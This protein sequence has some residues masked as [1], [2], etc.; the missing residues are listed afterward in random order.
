MLILFALDCGSQ[1]AS[2]EGLRPQKSVL[3]FSWFFAVFSLVITKKMELLLW[4]AFLARAF[5]H[6]MDKM[7][8]FLCFCVS[9]NC[10]RAHPFPLPLLPD[11]VATS[12]FYTT[13]SHIEKKLKERRKEGERETEREREERKRKRESVGARRPRKKSFLA[14]NH[15]VCRRWLPVNKYS[16]SQLK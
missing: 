11:D 4:R 5:Q 13:E 3:I 7:L 6:W 12:D 14:R 8:G 2:W 1:N 15:S 16:T 10:S 9:K